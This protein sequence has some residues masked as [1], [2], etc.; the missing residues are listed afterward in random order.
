MSWRAK[1]SNPGAGV[2]FCALQIDPDTHPE[3]YAV[4]TMS[5]SGKGGGSSRSV[6]LT[7]RLLLESGCEWV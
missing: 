4:G 3:S 7:V 1:I 6:L 2:I 5:F